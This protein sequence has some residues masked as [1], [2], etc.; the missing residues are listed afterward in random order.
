MTITDAELDEWEDAPDQYGTLASND[1]IRRLISEVRRLQKGDEGWVM[2]HDKQFFE[3]KELKDLLKRADE[4]LESLGNH[5]GIA[6]S[7][8]IEYE[9]LRIDIAAILKGSEKEGKS[10]C[11]FCKEEVSLYEEH[12]EKDGKVWHDKCTS[13]K[14]SMT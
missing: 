7:F 6:M 1:R 12:W 10:L 8:Y 2:M 9:P 11:H 14:E 4:M 5:I 13:F 3:I